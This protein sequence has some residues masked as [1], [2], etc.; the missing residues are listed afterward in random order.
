MIERARGAVAALMVVTLTG[1]VCAQTLDADAKEIAAYRLSLDTSKNVQAATRAMV[2]EAKKDPKL[3]ARMKLDAEIEAL[4]AGVSAENVAF[5]EAHEADLKARC[6][7]NSSGS[8]R[9]GKRFAG[10]P[11]GG[12]GS[13]YTSWFW[14]LAGTPR[15]GNICQKLRP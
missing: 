1:G 15:G 8:A 2:E 5:V 7:R 11:V 6:R 4:E 13:W 14:R 3:Q 9:A 10:V 12:P